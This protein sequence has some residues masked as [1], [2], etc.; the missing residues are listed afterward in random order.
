MTDHDRRWTSVKTL[1]VAGAVA[2][3]A[4]IAIVVVVIWL[5]R[6]GLL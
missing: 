3:A 6:H 1:S 2:I 4:A 5:A